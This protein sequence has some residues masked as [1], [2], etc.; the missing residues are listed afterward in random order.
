MHAAAANMPSSPVALTVR[1]AQ[2]ALRKRD[3]ES[4]LLDRLLNGP[5]AAAPLQGPSALSAPCAS[6]MHDCSVNIRCRRLRT[7]AA[8]IT[9][10]MMSF[11]SCNLR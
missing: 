1:V 7:A 4:E 10:S 8:T 5:Q 3:L 9:H 2:Q 11:A 6:V